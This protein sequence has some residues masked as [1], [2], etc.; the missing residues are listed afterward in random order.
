MTF[1]DNS[2]LIACKS[3]QSP[4]NAVHHLSDT[5]PCI[6]EAS[7]GHQYT[8]SD[9]EQSFLEKSFLQNQKR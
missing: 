8:P 9:N 3:L 7:N 5:Q 1:F 2:A 4:T 6:E